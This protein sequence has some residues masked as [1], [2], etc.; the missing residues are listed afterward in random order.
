[1]TSPAPKAVDLA[2]VRAAVDE[3]ASATSIRAGHRQ[4]RRRHGQIPG[5][6]TSRQARGGPRSGQEMTGAREVAY[7]PDVSVVGAK[8]SGELFTSGICWPC[9]SRS[10]LMLVYI[11]FRF[12]LQFGLGAVVGLFHDVILVFGLIA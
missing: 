7:S 1:M 2:K 8:V 10:L 12:E 4:R 11:W 3:R 9:W 5:A 6:G